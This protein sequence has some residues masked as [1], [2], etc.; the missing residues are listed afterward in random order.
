MKI[1]FI[2]L[3]NM[4]KA[5]LG[6]ILRM[7]IAE[8]ADIM[9]YAKTEVSRQKAKEDFG[10]LIGA[11]NEEVAEFA[12]ILVLAIKPQVIPSVL[13]GLSEQMTEDTIVLSIAAGLS[14]EKLCALLGKKVKLVRCMPNTPAMVGEGCSAACKNELVSDSDMEMCMK[15][16]TSLG[17]A[18]EIPETMM[19]A[20]VGLSGSS[21]A[22]V[23]MFIEALA[24]G[25]VKEGIPRALAYKFAAQSV[26][27]SAKLMLQSGKHPGELKD[28]VCSP[29]GTTIEAVQTLEDLGLRSAVM[30]A[31][32]A[33][34]E[35]SR[36]LDKK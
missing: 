35:K 22:Y 4:A 3:G 20:I 21:P 34:T 36:E 17:M 15:V 26:L 19:D 9:A 32:S 25:A 29:G 12:D 14:M 11:S 33:A 8:P 28:M 10:I 1:G 24:D 30:N 5:M 13:P 7:K 18:E 2:G 16:L 31:V 23:F 27:G 6:G